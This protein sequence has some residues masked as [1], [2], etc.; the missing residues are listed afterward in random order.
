MKNYESV[1]SP[2]VLVVPNN[3]ILVLT[4]PPDTSDKVMSEMQDKVAAFF[5]DRKALVIRSGDVEIGY[6]LWE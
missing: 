5:G 1:I 3:G 6:I 2:D 4:M